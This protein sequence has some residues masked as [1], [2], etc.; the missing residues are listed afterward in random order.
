LNSIPSARSVG[1]DVEAFLNR[2]LTGKKLT[3]DQV[4]QVDTI[5]GEIEHLAQSKQERANQTLTKMN[6]ATSVD[7]LKKIDNEYRNQGQ[8]AEGGRF[9]VGDKTYNIPPDKVKDFL[10]DNPNARKL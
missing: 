7:E 10:A 8:S 1:G 4:K 6:A 2:T 3:D 5:L 9:Q